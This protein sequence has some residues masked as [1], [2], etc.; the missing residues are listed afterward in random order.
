MI[1]MNINERVSD[2]PEMY[3]RGRVRKLFASADERRRPTQR[4]VQLRLTRTR[5]SM[6]VL[7]EERLAKLGYLEKHFSDISTMFQEADDVLLGRIVYA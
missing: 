4:Y 6:R 2:R 7:S 3:E 5:P 1:T